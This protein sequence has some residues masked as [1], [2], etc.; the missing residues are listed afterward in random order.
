MIKTSLILILLILPWTASA[1]YLPFTWAQEVPSGT[2]DSSNVTFTLAHTPKYPAA[3]H[4]SLDG[5]VQKQTTDYS[6]SGS[7]ITFVS[8]P[9]TGSTL[10]CDYVY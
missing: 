6:L 2:V 10:Y 3:L 8:A 1:T 5:L 9:V 7:T 4:C